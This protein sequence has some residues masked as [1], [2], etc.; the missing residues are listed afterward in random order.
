MILLLTPMAPETREKC[1]KYAQV[2]TLLNAFVNFGLMSTVYLEEIE[3]PAWTDKDDKL[4]VISQGSNGFNCLTGVGTF[5]LRIS[6]DDQPEV[7]AVGAAVAVICSSGK[8]VTDGLKFGED[9][10]RQRDPR[11]LANTF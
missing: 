6:A 5:L 2:I 4:S 3:Q 10:K 11:L 8:V 9:Y 7:A 1:K